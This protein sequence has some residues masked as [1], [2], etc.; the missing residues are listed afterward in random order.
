[1]FSFFN[2]FTINSKWC[3]NITAKD[4]QESLDTV[5]FFI[6]LIRSMHNKK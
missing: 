6:N 4:F 5:D 1:M 2:E 3:Y